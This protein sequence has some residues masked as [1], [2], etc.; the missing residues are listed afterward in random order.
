MTITMN[1]QIEILDSDTGEVMFVDAI[2]VSEN[3]NKG[4]VTIKSTVPYDIQLGSAYTIRVQ[5]SIF[6]DD[7][8]LVRTDTKNYERVRL[9][10]AN[11]SYSANKSVM[12]YAFE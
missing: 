2:S 10:K 8:V 9:Q 3:I 12:I 11:E 5:L 6:D 4:I 1:P 7:E